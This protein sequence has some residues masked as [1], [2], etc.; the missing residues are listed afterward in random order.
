MDPALN[1]TES[2]LKIIED[3]RGQSSQT[4]NFISAIILFLL[5]ALKT[6]THYR[7]IVRI[8]SVYIHTNGVSSSYDPFLKKKK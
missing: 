4:A 2:F 7:K 3:A 6:L 8:P 1:V 5:L